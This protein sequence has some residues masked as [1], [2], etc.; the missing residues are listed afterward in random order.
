MPLDWTIEDLVH[1]AKEDSKKPYSTLLQAIELGRRVRVLARGIP[2]APAPMLPREGFLYWCGAIVYRTSHKWDAVVLITGDVGDGKSTLAMRMAQRIDR[3]FTIGS[4]LCYTATELLEIYK[5]ILPGQVV[6]FDEGVRGL[7]AG[8]QATAEQ[9]ALIQ[10]LAL[11]REKGAVLFICAPSIWNIAK[12]VRQNRAWLWIHVQSR[13]VA[14]IHERIKRLFYTQAPELGFD[15]SRDCPFLQWNKYQPTSSF[16]KE[17]QRV[18]SEHLDAYLIETVNMLRSKKDKHAAQVADSAERRRKAGV[19][20][21]EILK[22]IKQAMTPA[23]R[24]RK[25]RE[26]ALEIARLE[27]EQSLNTS[28]G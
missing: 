12:Q 1:L 11:I 15:M 5:V 25:Q 8:D 7:L 21:A 3:S 19:P 6:L 26:R 27:A 17:Y 4:R 16:F 20:T 18:K 23:E 10:A 22:D 28:G 24:K 13:G 14:R 2:T 9:K